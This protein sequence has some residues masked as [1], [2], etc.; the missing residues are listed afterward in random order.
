MTDYSDAAKKYAGTRYREG[1]SIVGGREAARA[2]DAGHAAALATVAPVQ[3]RVL[4]TAEELDAL[5]VGCI[6]LDRENDS[7]HRHQYDWKCATSNYDRPDRYL[8]CRLVYDPTAPVP[9]TTEPVRLTA[10]D[11]RWRDGA[12]VRG[13]FADGSAIEGTLHAYKR[14]EIHYRE[15][16]GFMYADAFARVYLLAEAPDDDEPIL[17]ALRVDGFVDAQLASL[18]AAGYDVVKV[19]S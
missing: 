12:K 9:A 17:D 10:D 14:A 1:V 18:R 8:P 3:P 5:G 19:E 6:V 15:D 16:N 4:T 11:P 2:F 13:E 7:W